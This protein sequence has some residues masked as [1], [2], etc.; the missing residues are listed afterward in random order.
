MGDKIELNSSV[1]SA[2]FIQ[3]TRG[4]F[5]NPPGG[6]IVFKMIISRLPLEVDKISA[7]LVNEENYNPRNIRIHCVEYK[8]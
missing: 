2:L 6:N 8:A 5:L 3:N 1:K 7:D 4:N